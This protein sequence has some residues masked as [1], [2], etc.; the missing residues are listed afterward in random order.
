MNFVEKNVSVLKPGNL[1]LS[2]I[3]VTTVL[4]LL[5]WSWVD[6]TS[7][8]KTVNTHEGIL[9]EIN[10]QDLGNGIRY[11][12]DQYKTIASMLTAIILSAMV[13]GVVL[14]KIN[15]E[16]IMSD[17]AE[18]SALFL[19]TL[20]GII[21]ITLDIVPEEVADADSLSETQ[22]DNSYGITGLIFISIVGGILVGKTKLARDF[23]FLGTSIYTTLMC[24][25][26]G[27]V[28][29][30]YW[31]TKVHNDKYTEEERAAA[32][33]ET[34]GIDRNFKRQLSESEYYTV[35]SALVLTAIVVFISF[36]HMYLER[37][38]MSKFFGKS[39]PKRSSSPKRVSPKRTTKRK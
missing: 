24:V 18:L 15:N 30:V 16:F 29:Y 4:G 35:L 14:S 38:N 26:L 19:F 37:K 1:T 36:F 22:R 28:A 12:S 8:S 11:E 17:T 33:N 23:S 3:L 27:I 10:E 6:F 21:L 2:L 9:L 5:G 31:L 25:I 13:V 39:S 7:D 34:P 32:Q 20:V